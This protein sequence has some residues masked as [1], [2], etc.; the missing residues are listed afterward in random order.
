M[1]EDRARI[2]TDIMEKVSTGF[3]YD[4]YL[5]S[6]KVQSVVLVAGEE[7]TPERRGQDS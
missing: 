4:V 2:Q 7:I 3:M 6:Q 5:I 1:A